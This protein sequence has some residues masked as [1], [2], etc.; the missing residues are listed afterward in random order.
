MT[1]SRLRVSI[2]FAGMANQ[3]KQTV[4]NSPKYLLER[5]AS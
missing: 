2:T 1:V 3:F 4:G 5:T